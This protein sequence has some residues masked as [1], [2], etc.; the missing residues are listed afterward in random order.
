MKI[1]K[2]LRISNGAATFLTDTKDEKGNYV[3]AVA[4]RLACGGGIESAA[5]ALCGLDASDVPEEGDDVWTFGETRVMKNANAGKKAA[6]GYVIPEESTLIDV[7]PPKQLRKG[8]VA[9]MDKVA[10][11]APKPAEEADA[12]A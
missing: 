1:I 6:S 12:L 11:K 9:L 10:P 7:R 2:C 8:L 3:K 5:N 4:S